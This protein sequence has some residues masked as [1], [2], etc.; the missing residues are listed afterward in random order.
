MRHC[1]F[2]EC[3]RL[4]AFCNE[5]VLENFAKFT[6]NLAKLVKTPIL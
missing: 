6:V 4:E 5:G 3:S 1:K 2:D